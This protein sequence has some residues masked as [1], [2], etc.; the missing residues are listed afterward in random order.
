MVLEW[1]RRNDEA[2]SKELKDYLLTTTPIAH[3]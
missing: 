3:G 2:F 1:S